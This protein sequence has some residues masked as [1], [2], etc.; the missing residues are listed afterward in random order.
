MGLAQSDHVV[1]LHFGGPFLQEPSGPKVT[2]GL[3]ATWAIIAG[4]WHAASSN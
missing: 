1:S 3:Q 2:L 4:R